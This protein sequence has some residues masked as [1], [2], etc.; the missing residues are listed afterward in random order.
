MMGI[1]I[2]GMEVRKFIKAIR[3][4]LKQK[5]I[6]ERR[7]IS[8]AYIVRFLA[9][10]FARIVRVVFI[11]INTALGYIESQTERIIRKIGKE[12]LIKE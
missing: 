9:V 6:K 1:V 7:K 10:S 11:R 12:I 2:F 8:S 3:S 5:K 4:S